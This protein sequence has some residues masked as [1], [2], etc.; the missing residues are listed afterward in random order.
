M[1]EGGS[2]AIIPARGGSKRLP[3]KNIKLLAGRALIAWTIDAAIKAGVFDRIIVSTEDDEIASISREAGAE[4]PFLRPSH[5]SS[6]HAT[7]DDVVEHAVN[8]LTEKD[9]YNVERVTV[10]QP[11]SPL[12]GSKNIA[13]AFKLLDKKN[14]DGIVSVCEC[15]HP[16][17]FSGRLSDDL[18]LHNF[19]SPENLKRGQ[20]L[21]KSYRLNGAIYI[22]TKE[23]IGNSRSLYTGA[24][25]VYAYKMSVEDSVDIDNEIDF[26]WAEFLLNRVDKS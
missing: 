6:D 23:L 10:L 20:D 4:V 12:R 16:V 2:V 24:H 14:A 25:R 13:D 18:S 7:T 9:S 3:R 19:I 11:T 15:E 17:E 26:L 8:W 1:S 22:Y 21:P 5:L